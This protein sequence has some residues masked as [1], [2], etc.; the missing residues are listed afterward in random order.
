MGLGVNGGG[1]GVT[2]FLVEQGAEVTVTD[3][4]SADVLES[5]LAALAGLPVRYVLGRHDEADFRRADL[6]IRNPA[7]PRESPLVTDCA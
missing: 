5:T 7:V 6:V 4:R 3:L 2:R 1:L